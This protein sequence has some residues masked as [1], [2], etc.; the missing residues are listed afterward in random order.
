MMIQ[1]RNLK[2]KVTLY[3]Q[4]HY[5]EQLSFYKKKIFGDPEKKV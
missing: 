4:T 5:E 1:L 2:S 3:Y